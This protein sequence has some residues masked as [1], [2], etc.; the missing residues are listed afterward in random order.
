MFYRIAFFLCCASL[1]TRQANRWQQ[2]ARARQSKM[3]AKRSARAG[4]LLERAARQE[5]YSFR[6]GSSEL[7]Y[8]CEKELF[9]P[10]RSGEM[11]SIRCCFSS[12]PKERRHASCR[13]PSPSFREE[14]L[15]KQGKRGGSVWQSRSLLIV[16]CLHAGLVTAQVVSPPFNSANRRHVAN[17]IN[18]LSAQGQLTPG[19]AGVAATLSG[20]NNAQ[21]NNALDQLHPA[22]FSDLTEIQSSMGGQILS[23]FHRRP[24]I[25][26]ACGEGKWRAFADPIGNWLREGN[27]GE[28]TGFVSGT[29]GI[30]VGFDRSIGEHW[31]TGG[32]IVYNHTDMTMHL[33]RGTGMVNRYLAVFNTDFNMDCFYCGISLYGGLDENSIQRHIHFTSTDLWARSHFSSIDMGGQFD[34]AYIFRLPCFLIYP[35][36]NFD[37]FHFKANSFSESGA[38]G[39]DLNVGEN[40]SQ[41]IRS[42]AGIGFQLL[43][44]NIAETICVVPSISF[45]WAMECPIDRPAY[46]AYFDG[47]PLSFEAKGWDH[48][49]QL[50]AV[51]FIL[52]IYI[53][54]FVLAGEYMSES[55]PSAL[56]DYWAQR[57]NITLQYSW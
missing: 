48:T 36:G 56:D 3:E 8:D 26:Y 34:T 42:S 16:A 38:D 2:S 31:S 57:C 23:L 32:G 5:S 18:T 33:G 9:A 21:L 50:L 44:A 11:R 43:D 27:L 1:L 13:S 25:Q 51:D 29:K 39:L 45:G 30:A 12:T 4:P 15:Q 17:N 49:Y 14:V 47:E 37:Y 35:Y 41:T 19:L 54:D 46:T 24:I 28:Q 55:S 10:F 22:P 52:A 6:G 53:Y 40:S 20:L 7:S